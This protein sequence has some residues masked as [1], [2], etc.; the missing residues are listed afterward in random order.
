[1][2][3]CVG[4]LLAAAAAHN[5]VETTRPKRAHDADIAGQHAGFRSGTPAWIRDAKG[6]LLNKIAN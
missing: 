3:T 4:G 6:A 5:E 1:M 2:L